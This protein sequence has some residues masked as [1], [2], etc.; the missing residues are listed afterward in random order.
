MWNL[1]IRTIT[2]EFRS[3]HS[4]YYLGMLE[5][6]LKST[7]FAAAG[8]HSSLVRWRFLFGTFSTAIQSTSY[9]ANPS[10]LSIDRHSPFFKHKT[11]CTNFLRVRIVLRPV[12][13]FNVVSVI[14]Y[15]L[16]LLLA[17]CCGFEPGSTYLSIA[18]RFGHFQFSVCVHVDFQSSICHH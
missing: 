4:G 12:R 2:S 6:L 16:L 14:N 10:D 5:L 11:P 7:E 18:L 17:L 8:T 3:K 15:Y 1:L 13:D 9:A